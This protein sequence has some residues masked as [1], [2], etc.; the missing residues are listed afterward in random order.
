VPLLFVLS[1]VAMMP[2][3]ELG[4][5]NCQLVMLAWLLACGAGV[6]GFGVRS[7]LRAPVLLG[8]PLQAVEWIFDFRFTEPRPF[9]SFMFV[10]APWWAIAYAVASYKLA[11]ML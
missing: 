11:R 3:R 1:V 2:S 6:A 4:V 8:R 5:R 10:Q 9:H 7:L